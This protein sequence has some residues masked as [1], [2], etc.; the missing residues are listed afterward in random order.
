LVIAF[1][2]TPAGAV[3]DHLPF[4][5]FSILEPAIAILLDEQ[6]NRSDGR[7]LLS[8]LPAPIAN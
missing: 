1:A 6:P 3:M 2:P 5:E 7:N 8:G 4:G